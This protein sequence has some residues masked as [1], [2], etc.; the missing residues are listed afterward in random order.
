MP[1]QK[2]PTASLPV[3]FRGPPTLP[4]S[5]SGVRVHWPVCPP[6]RSAPLGSQHELRYHRIEV[7]QALRPACDAHVREADLLEP[8]ELDVLRRVAGLGHPRKG[9]D[10]VRGAVALLE[11]LVHRGE[12]ALPV[13]LEGRPEAAV[14]LLRLGLVVHPEDGLLGDGAEGVEGRLGAVEDVPHVALRRE[15]QRLEPRLVVR[16]ALRLQDVLQALHEVLVSDAAEAQDGATRLD[17]L[18][19]L[20]RDVAGEGEAR[21]LAEDL[22]RPPHCL[23]RRPGHAVGLVQDDDL[24]LALRQGH[25]LLREAL[26]LLPHHVDAAV[27][28]G[29]EL[30][31]PL[32]IVLAQVLP[33][34]A[35]HHRGLATTGR[36]AEE[37]VREGAAGCMCL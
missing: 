4:G 33:C 30:Y 15:D 36:A 6:S 20:R 16:R 21:R 31:A 23:L 14:D 28:G 26:D 34:Q 32:L 1:P 3:G 19:D 17:G 2:T 11:D 22:H 12:G 9:R 25:L 5:C 8:L 13:P 24:E 27:I 35:M 7:Q 10:D 29:V 18:D 37:E